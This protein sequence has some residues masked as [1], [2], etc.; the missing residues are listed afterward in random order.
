MKLNRT[1]AQTKKLYTG[2]FS[3]KVVA[4]NPTADE[5]AELIGYER[6]DSSEELKYEGTDEKSQQPFVSL[7]FWLKS[8]TPEPKFFNA[9]FRL[10][11]KQVVGKD[12]GKVQ[13][14]NQTG[15]ATYVDNESNLPD[16]FTKF[17]NKDKKN[18]AD[19]I[20]REAIQGEANLYNF[21][22]AWLGNVEFWDYEKMMRVGDEP[23]DVLIDK[24]RLFRNVD[25]YVNDEYRWMIKG[26]E[27]YDAETDRTA[28]AE[29]GKTLLTA[30]VVAL[31]T[32]YST[33]KDGE[34][35]MYQNLYGEYLRLYM[36]KKINVY[37]ASGHWMRPNLQP[38]DK[39]EPLEKW[40]EQLTGSHGCQDAYTLT[41]LQDFDPEKFQQSSK[42]TFVP[43]KEGDV[44]T[45]TS[46]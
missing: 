31:A 25:M 30:N 44:A 14:V 17:Q 39:R 12:S 9:R 34:L 19:K 23:T 35:K 32:V 29:K 3:G 38:T 21:L 41:A 45:D 7:S 33:E 8:D 20:Y 28:K 6:S 40:V 10:V 4:V 16:W 1:E 46:Y 2:F 26:Q 15:G 37:I 42:E 22:A 27:Q 5:L 24:D 18:L 36:L 13:Y 11:D 43:V